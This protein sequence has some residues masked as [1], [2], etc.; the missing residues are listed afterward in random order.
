M[1]DASNFG[2][3][4]IKY[5]GSN[6]DP[7]L[8]ENPIQFWILNTSGRVNT[9]YIKIMLEVYYNFSKIV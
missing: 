8:L 9:N 1:K 3:N 2:L 5:L 7:E 4:K 6:S